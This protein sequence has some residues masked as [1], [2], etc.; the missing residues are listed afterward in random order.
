MISP[1]WVVAYVG[2]WKQLEVVQ[3][4]QREGWEPYAPQETVVAYRARVRGSEV[5]HRIVKRRPLFGGYLF[6]RELVRPLRREPER[7][8]FS[9]LGDSQGPIE[10]NPAWIEETKRLEAE[11][12]WDALRRPQ[13]RFFEGQRVRVATGPYADF[14]AIVDRLEKTGK[15]KVKFRLFGRDV[16]AK[17][18]PGNLFVPEA[19][20]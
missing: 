5:R 14:W 13:A 19:V 17:V 2:A 16:T 18:E 11:G 3:R 12:A 7:R 6:V 10:V 1:R 20:A 9:I 4:L 15:V 8:I